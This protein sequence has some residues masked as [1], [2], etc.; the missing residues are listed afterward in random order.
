MAPDGPLFHL[1]P[2]KPARRER[3]QE[4]RK[5]WLRVQWHQDFSHIITLLFPTICELGIIITHLW[6]GGSCM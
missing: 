3:R 5:P 4:A 1:N 2:S 6:K